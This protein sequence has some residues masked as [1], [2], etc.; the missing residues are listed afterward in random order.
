M[1]VCYLFVFSLVICLLFFFFQSDFLLRNRF[2]LCSQVVD[3][4]G[5]QQ[6]FLFVLFG[7]DY[8]DVFSN[9]VVSLLIVCL[10]VFMLLEVQM[11]WW[12]V[13][14]VNNGNVNRYNGFIV[15]WLFWCNLIGL[16]VIY[17]QCLIVS[18]FQVF[19]E[20]GKVGFMLSRGCIFVIL[21]QYQCIGVF[22]L[23]VWQQFLINNGMQIIWVGLN[24]WL[25]IFQVIEC[26]LCCFVYQFIWIGLVC[27]GCC[28]Q[29]CN[30][31]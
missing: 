9:Y 29:R 21:V 28:I 11:Y 31:Q 27:C 1:L 10:G 19:M 26:F 14:W 6:C 16:I 2:Q 25:F 30:Y 13:I 22:Y 4:F 7:G 5:M 15:Q 3:I 18:L 8:I 12:M 17:C 20:S 24:L 23:Y